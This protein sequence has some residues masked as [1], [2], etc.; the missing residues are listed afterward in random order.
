M[1]TFTFGFSA[2][3]RR[4]KLTIMDVS[5]EKL[6]IVCLCAW[7]RNMAG[8]EG[9]VRSQPRRVKMN[10]L[11]SRASNLGTTPITW[12]NS[13]YNEARIRM[14]SALTLF[15]AHRP[16]PSQPCQHPGR[17]GKGPSRL[18]KAERRCLPCAFEIGRTTMDGL[19]PRRRPYS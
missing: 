13:L 11:L 7:R 4:K 1:W 18:Q 12:Q 9:A 10:A 17:G 5:S 14:R 8:H 15:A 16:V 6:V 2:E 3:A 19:K